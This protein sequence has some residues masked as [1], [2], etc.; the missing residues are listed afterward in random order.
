MKRGQISTE[1]IMIIGLIFLVTLPLFAYA[2]VEVTRSI[3]MNHA[4]DAVNTLANAANTVYALG[5]G[6][7]K[8]VWI[9][10]PGGVVSQSVSNKE[11]SLKLHIF[12]GDSDVFADTKPTVIG[13]IPTS[14]GQHRIAVESLGSGRVRIGEAE[15]DTTSP[16][17]TRIYPDLSPGQKLCA[18]TITI[19]ADTDEAA[20]CKYLK[21]EGYTPDE[22]DWESS[23]WEAFEGKALSHYTTEYLSE[24]IYSYYARCE[25]YADPVNMLMNYAHNCLEGREYCEA[26]S[27]GV[28]PTVNTVNITIEV[29]V[30]CLGVAGPGGLYGPGGPCEDEAV[31]LTP[32]VVHLDSPPNYQEI[33]GAPIVTFKYWVT[34]VADQGNPSEGIAYCVLNVSTF[35][36]NPIGEEYPAGDDPL[37]TYI[38]VYDLTPSITT[39]P[40]TPILNEITYPF[41]DKG[42]FNWNIFCVDASCASNKGISAE[43]RRIKIDKTFFEA[44]LTSCSGWCGYVQQ[45][46]GEC[47]TATSHCTEYCDTPYAI[48]VPQPPSSS[49][50]TYV[51]HYTGQKCYAGPGIDDLYCKLPGETTPSKV[52]CCKAQEKCTG[53]LDEDEDSVVDCNDPDCFDADNCK[54][55]ICNDNIDN[56]GDGYKDCCDTDCYSNSYCTSTEKCCNNVRDDDGDGKTDCCDTDCYQRPNY[57]PAC[58][59]ET[60]CNDGLD[61]DGDGKIDCIPGNKDTTNCPC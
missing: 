50:Y 45:S 36:E 30:P 58:E 61:N 38:N 26:H 21:N 27:E 12:G 10:T 54:E 59:K 31:D 47:E 46:G 37:W 3:Q 56:D 55:T 11:I 28:L 49:P 52:C 16:E 34:D 24:G 5:P 25:D 7:K 41:S 6:S 20:K 32:P 17:I 42:W 1:Y 43:D 14:K 23:T 39:N 9:N 4:E 48:G 35:S 33:I 44:F 15:E 57:N 29:G 2:F 40:N 8:Y 18:G 22:V 13:S 53:G 60:C 51:A 19:G